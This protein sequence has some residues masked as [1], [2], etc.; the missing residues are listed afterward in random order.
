MED[1]GFC[2]TVTHNPNTHFD[3]GD[4]YSVSIHFPRRLTDGKTRSHGAAL[5]I[6][7][8]LEIEDEFSRQGNKGTPKLLGIEKDEGKNDGDSV[9]KEEAEGK[10]LCI[11]SHDDSGIKGEVEDDKDIGSH[12]RGGKAAILRFLGISASS[13]K[14]K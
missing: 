2:A 6:P 14:Y 7:T 11:S 12:K 3:N 5:T 4:F 13:G 9:T 8:T 1:C 10:Y